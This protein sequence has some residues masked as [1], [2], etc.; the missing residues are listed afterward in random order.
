MCHFYIVS[1]IQN[2]DGSYKND[3]RNIPNKNRSLLFVYLS[4]FFPY[5]CTFTKKM[6]NRKFIYMKI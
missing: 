4:Q 5:T 6:N 2:I 1:N 3:V